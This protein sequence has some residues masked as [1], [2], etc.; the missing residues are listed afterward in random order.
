MQQRGVRNTVHLC[1]HT[2]HDIGRYRQTLCAMHL[3]K[4]HSGHLLT[5][6]QRAQGH[7]TLQRLTY[8]GKAPN[9]KLNLA[10][11]QNVSW[12]SNVTFFPD[13]TFYKTRDKRMAEYTVLL[14]AQPFLQ[15]IRVYKCPGILG[16]LQ[17]VEGTVLRL[18]WAHAVIYGFGCQRGVWSETKQIIPMFHVEDTTY[19]LFLLDFH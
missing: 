13:Q 16:P 17:Q 1:S 18:P 19:N 15:D 9:I 7:S 3:R 6:W 10:H 8:F 11:H 4:W 5:T 2:S 14:W 12:N